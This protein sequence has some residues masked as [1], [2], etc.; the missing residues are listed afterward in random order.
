M[1]IR[2]DS[3]LVPWRPFFWNDAE[4]VLLLLTIYPE[5]HCVREVREVAPACP[6]SLRPDSRPAS[7]SRVGPELCA[8]CPISRPS[9]RDVTK[10]PAVIKI[11]RRVRRLHRRLCCLLSVGCVYA[12]GSSGRRRPPVKRPR[13]RGVRRDRPSAIPPV[14]SALRVISGGDPSKNR[15]R[16]ASVGMESKVSPTVSKMARTRLNRR[17]RAA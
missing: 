10:R 9:R 6:H 1:G 11:Q 17:S 2:G 14:P 3:A 4:V 15:T 12:R 16:C 5:P 13:L 8:L 7:P